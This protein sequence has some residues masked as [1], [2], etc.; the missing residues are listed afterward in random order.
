MYIE[1]HLHTPKSFLDGMVDPD[2][3]FVQLKELGIPAAAITDHGNMFGVIPF[4][5]SAKKHGIKPIIGCEV[6]HTIQPASTVKEDQFGRRYYHLILLAKNNKGYAN[7]SKIVSLA[8]NKENSYYKPRTDLETLRKYS[9]GI[10]CNSACLGGLLNVMI[11]NDQYQLAL[12]YAKE[13]QDI[14]GKENFFIELQNH[15]IPQQQHNNPLLEKIAHEIG[16]KIIIANDVHYL[17]EED[18]EKHD[19]LLAIQTNSLISDPT[20][21]KFPSNDF[22]LKT[23]DQLKLMFPNAPQE[24]FDNTMLIADMCNVDL[25]FHEYILPDFYQYHD[26]SPYKTTKEYLRHLCE[27]GIQNFFV[28]EG[29]EF[30]EKYKERLD[31]EIDVIEKMGFIS[32]FLIVIDFI[33]YAKSKDIFV[34]PGR[35]CLHRDS[36]ILTPYGF[37]NINECK[38]GDEVFDENGNII[39]LSMSMSYDCDEK[40]IE[41]KGYYGG[42]GNK[43]TA[44]H[45]VL[46]S[47]KEKTKKGT[48]LNIPNKPQWISAQNIEVGDLVV[49]PKLNLPVLV[50]EL[51]CD[52]PKYD[53]IS[54]KYSKYSLNSVSKKIRVSKETLKK[55]KNNEKSKSDDKILKFLKHNNISRS[56]LGNSIKSSILKSNKLKMNYDLGKIFGIFISDGWLR[57]NKENVIGFAVQKSFD[58]LVIP[59]L[60]N[61]VFGLECTINDSKTKDLRQYTLHHKGLSDLFKD[62]FSDY[63]YSA[64][65]KYIP[66]KLMF[67]NENFRKGLLDGL[68]YGDGSHKGK[69]SYT[70][71]SKTLAENVHTLLLSLNLPSSI[72][73]EN[74]INKRRKSFNEDGRNDYSTN[75]KITTSH[76]FDN[77]NIIKNCGY[78][79][80]GQFLYY[81]VREINEVKGDGKV[82]DITVPSTHSYVTDSYVVHNSGAGSLVAY[83]TQI[84]T[85]NPMELNLQFERF[86]NP[87]RNEMPDFDVDFEQRNR[88]IVMNYV[89]EKYG[90]DNCAQIATFIMLQ[91]KSAN[92]DVARAM[93]IDSHLIDQM[94]KLINADPLYKDYNMTQLYDVSPELQTFV[95]QQDEELFKKMFQY[96]DMVLG[97]PRQPSVHAAGMIIAD[98]DINNFA[99]TFFTK[100]K[101]GQEVKVLQASKGPAESIGLVKMDFLGLK[102]L[103]IVKITRSLVR[104]KIPDFSLDKIDLK[105]RKV[106]Q[107]FE[108]GETSLV[109]QFESP[110]MR[111]TLK[112]MRVSSFEEII[113]AV[114]L[115]RPGPMDNI[116]TYIRNKNNPD[117]IEYLHPI[118]K[119][120]LDETYGVMVYQEQVMS[121]FREMGGFS[122]GHADIVRKAISKKDEKILN[123]ELNNFYKGCQDN[124]ISV[125]IAKEIVSQI[126]S[127]A[128]YAFNKAHAACYAYVAYLTAYLKV[129]FPVEFLAATLTISLASKERLRNVISIC[130]NEMKIPIQAPHINISENDFVNDEDVIVFGFQGISGIGGI[131]AQQIVDERNANGPYTSL[132]NFCERNPR[133]SEANINSLIKVG[134]F[135]YLNKSRSTLLGELSETIE[136]VRKINKQTKDIHNLFV[137]LIPN[138][139]IE[140]KIAEKVKVFPRDDNEEYV[141]QWEKELIG[142]LLT[143][144]PL[145]KYKSLINSG[146]IDTVSSLRE[147]YEKDEIRP[148]ESFLLLAIV[149]EFKQFTSKKGDLM[150]SGALEDEYDS[151]S[152]VY[153]AN[154]LKSVSPQSALRNQGVPVVLIEGQINQRN[155]GLGV[156]FMKEYDLSNLEN[157]TFEQVDNY[158]KTSIDQRLLKRIKKH[159][160]EI[161][162]KTQGKNRSVKIKVDSI[163]QMSSLVKVLNQAKNGTHLVYIYM[164]FVDNQNLFTY[165]NIAI[166]C[167]D[168]IV[169]K[170]KDVFGANNV[171]VE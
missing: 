80:D 98:Q 166:P 165:K 170:L 120:I 101:D 93:G 91:P 86:L 27:E 18:F 132:I 106:L 136:E 105:D 82:F 87:E 119:P 19:T 73:I 156:I 109:F 76:N 89:R 121:I 48:Y 24:Y 47:K 26:I 57:K 45:K 16:A 95:K 147:K 125:D 34:G 10:I 103:D 12:D 167:N 55:F 83:L 162:N 40:L 124:N 131:L 69:S 15:G 35:G 14:F 61:N 123:T 63:N 33:Q 42:N 60:I 13:L 5:Q 163:A 118:L 159:S 75:Y 122:M 126:E 85:L 102:T 41:I 160:F 81:R 78:A 4:Y 138:Y 113:A 130:K 108:H 168:L 143:Y 92:K 29:I 59:K 94:N 39:K 8:N 22:F 164:P 66:N 110:G 28:K 112:E 11:T 9:E 68:W 49:M 52:N 7:L 50:K 148:K 77:K 54:N 139:S 135:D 30:D 152:V 32:Y 161:K 74:R 116:P 64:H 53:R 134:A 142:L 157:A 17:N 150:A 141:I 100:D 71:V 6:Y 31:Y 72:K 58:D 107:I 25:D 3:M 127:F 62:I 169:K 97:S 133:A 104:K 154:N 67:T 51:I 145:D 96:A 44:D 158:L 23:E 149:D 2:K 155:E 36:K 117:A 65:T 140:D 151:L 137:E 146:Y 37:K 129:H 21:F 90:E 1:T 79:Y 153:F 114:A 115:Y 38:I 70:T 144:N 20:R 43:M 99:P 128:N 111:N 88:H 46:V 84:T 171:I 56:D